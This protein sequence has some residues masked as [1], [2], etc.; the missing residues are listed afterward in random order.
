MW[1]VTLQWYI[2]D[3]RA[4]RCIDDHNDSKAGNGRVTAMKGMGEGKEGSKI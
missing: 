1:Y 2:P 4:L 3:M